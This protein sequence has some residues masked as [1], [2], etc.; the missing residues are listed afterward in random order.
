[1]NIGIL[2]L[3]Q[4]GKST[5][6]DLLAAGQSTGSSG[7]AGGQSRLSVIQVPDE[8]IEYLSGV[9]K[10]KKTIF[11]TIEITDFAA[12]SKGASTSSSFSSRFLAEVKKADGLL[13]V[14]RAFPDPEELHPEGPPDP[15][16]DHSILV[17]ELILS[18]LTV[19]ESRIERIERSV[20]RGVKDGRAELELLTRC[21]QT[22]EEEKPLSSLS[23]SE[24]EELTLR[25]FALT[26]MK[27]MAT[28]LNVDEDQFGA[29]TLPEEDALREAFPGLATLRLSARI[30]AEIA[31]LP[32]EEERRE[33]MEDLGIEVAARDRLIRTCYE[34][35]GCISFLTVGEDE[36][37]AWTI[38]EGTAARQA[39]GKIH[40]DLERGFI[41]AETCSYADFRKHG[42]MA[43]LR[44]QGLLRL[45][46][47]D[48]VV[49]DGDILNIRFN[50]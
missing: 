14:V 21:R 37:R 8:R 22:L 9:Y 45:E 30:E 41:R 38:R 3:P 12:L 23:L 25:S 2:G 18:D 1:M 46:G 50:V 47:K 17:G 26:T 6:F 15:V 7:S 44:S 32:T 48:Y 39:A 4:C 27:P 40:S 28:V 20:A 33:F 10:P 43:A 49:Q 36:V 19:L 13:E 16:R 42:S 5:L 24:S 34:M 35:L 11:S 29:T 31:E